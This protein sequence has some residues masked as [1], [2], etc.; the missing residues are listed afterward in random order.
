MATEG[1]EHTE[2]YQIIKSFIK[3]RG[4]RN[5]F[6]A[7]EMSLLEVDEKKLLFFQFY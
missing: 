5:G 4:N 7:S 3:L 6:F 2:K 1:T